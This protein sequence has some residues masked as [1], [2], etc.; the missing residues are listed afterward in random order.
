MTKMTI[1][2]MIVKSAKTIMTTQLTSVRTK[3]RRKISTIARLKKLQQR[4]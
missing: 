2:T 4:Q 3:A 1:W